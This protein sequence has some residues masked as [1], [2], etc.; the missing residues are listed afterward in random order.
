MT[1]EEIIKSHGGAS[2][3]FDADAQKDDGTV[4]IHALGAGETKPPHRQ[5]RPP[6]PFSR[7]KQPPPR[8]SP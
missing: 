7:K 3:K 5:R 1:I 2:G 4:K 6:K 8:K